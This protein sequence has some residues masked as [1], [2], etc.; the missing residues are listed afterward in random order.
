MSCVVRGCVAP[1]GKKAVLCKKHWEAIPQNLRDDL[2]KG[3]EKGQHSLRAAPS[4]EW[5]NAVSKHVNDVKT[6]SVKVDEHTNKIT[7]QIEDKPV[8]TI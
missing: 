7:R 6:V 1:I 3:T 2:R 8:E 4:K 5:L